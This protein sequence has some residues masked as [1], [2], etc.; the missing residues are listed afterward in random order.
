MEAYAAMLDCVDQNVGQLVAFLESI[1]ELDNTI[2]LFSSDNG[3][4][5]AGGP[6]GMFNN[7]RR[8]MGLPPPPI[9]RERANA[10]SSAA[11]AAPRSIR[12][13][14]AKCRT[15]HFR[16]SRPTPVQAGGEYRSSR[17]GRRRS[18]TR[19]AIRRQ[20]VHVTDVMPT[21][22]DLAG[23]SRLQSVHGRPAR[24][25]HGASFAPVL[26]DAGAPSPRREQYY[27]CWS[28]RAYYRDGWLARSIQRR[29]APIDL[30]NW[31]LHHLDAD[32]SESVD[33]RAQHAAKLQELT[34]AFDA[35]AWQYFVYPLDN[36]DRLQ[37]FADSPPQATAAAD[38]PRTF[39]PGAQTTHRADVLPLIADRSFRIRVRFAHRVGDEGVLWAIGDPTGGMVLYVEDGRLHFQ[40]NGFGDET[41]LPAFELPAGEHEAILDYEALGKREGRGRILLGRTEKVRWTPLAPTLVLYGVFEGLDVGLDRRGPVLWELYERHGTFAYSGSIRDVPIEPGVRARS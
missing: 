3:G 2:I 41:T 20:F 14:G 35:A 30:E 8:Y 11:R 6:T 25:L 31:T 29:G 34:D 33:V 17:R 22:L 12:P 16:R 5:D 19:G 24:A 21:L 13:R 36:R 27:E 26:F 9:E 23:V 15:P 40:Y 32:F 39:H 10:P 38:L 1:G 37:K 4:T 18:A 28:N 7:N